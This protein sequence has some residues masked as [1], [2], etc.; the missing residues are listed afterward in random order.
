MINENFINEIKIGDVIQDDGWTGWWAGTV[1]AIDHDQHSIT[2]NRGDKYNE[3]FKD[4]WEPPGGPYDDDHEI[5]GSDEAWERVLVSG[6]KTETFVN[7]LFEWSDG[8]MI[9]WT[10]MGMS[11]L[12]ES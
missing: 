3:A 12:E 2:V 1:T 9:R 11:K 8:S 4:N 6:P 7:D 10:F 5:W